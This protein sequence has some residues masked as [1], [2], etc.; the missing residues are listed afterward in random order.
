VE[1]EAEQAVVLIV[2]CFNE[3]ARLDRDGLHGLAR[4]V[5]AALL[6]VDDGSTDGSGE[7][8]ATLCAEA[9]DRLH[10]LSLPRN[11]GKAEAVRRGLLAAIGDGARTVGYVDADLSTPAE[12]VARLV[13]VL[14]E[15]ERFGVFGSRI[16]ML[17]THIERR[18]LRH[19]L[20]RVFAVLAARILGVGVHDTQCGAKLFRADARLEAALAEPFSTRWVFD[21]ELIGR[22]LQG[23]PGVEPVPPEQLVEEPLRRWR[24]VPGSHLSILDM[25]SMAAGLA[26]TALAL[27]RW[28][29]GDGRRS[30]P[31]A[32][33][34]REASSR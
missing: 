25:V 29:S 24:H 12:E 31:A 8:L 26:W 7:L 19:A 4:C 10:L 28:R 6:L 14:R 2:P 33:G 20:G 16:R 21:V 9:P 30:T 32:V 34:R 22:L 15:R 3:A 23:R 13:A 5:G 11:L 17:G 27:R 1:A 18:W